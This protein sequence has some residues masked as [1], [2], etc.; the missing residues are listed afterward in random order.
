MLGRVNLC[1]LAAWMAL[2]TGDAFGQ[3][4]PPPG[5]A[6]QP[7]GEPTGWTLPPAGWMAA[8][9]NP[10]ASEEYCP[11]DVDP[12]IV[13][14]LL[15]ADR[16]FGWD[17]DSRLHDA[18]N[19]TSNGMWF[20]L[21]YTHTFIDNPGR[22]LL[23]GPLAA[24]PDPR[25]PFDVF[26]APVP[27]QVAVARVLDV[28]SVDF[29][30]I[31]GI[32]G[33]FGIPFRLGSFEAVFWG[34][35][36]STDVITTDEIPATNPLQDVDVI[37]TSLRNGGAPGSTVIFYDDSFRAPYTAQVFSAEANFYYNYRNPRLGLRIL[38]VL[39]FRH[40]DYDESLLQRGTFTNISGV[41]AGSILNDPLVRKID[42]WVDNNTY[43]VQTGLRS[44]FVHQHFTLG[45]EPRL[46]L[47][48]NHYEAT[49]RTEDL[50]DSPFP[51]IQDDGVVTTNITRDLFSTIFDLQLYAKVHLN[52]FVNLRVGYSYTWLGNISRAHSNI[53]YNDNGTAFPPAVVVRSNED[54]LWMSSFT[55][56]GEIILP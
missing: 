1:V 17:T 42:S 7:Y 16:G 28:S 32:R 31:N 33:T 14:E 29:D 18:L 39:G 44:E 55:I 35:E 48:V 40:T 2:T 47:G 34:T 8:H 41:A 49:V 19:S 10:G 13:N 12:R 23:G 50:R 4:G 24:V 30:N 38:P 53:Y 15:P 6:Y 9:G 27:G 26:A 3:Y 21:E 25:I 56:G 45:V 20:R 37:V 46:T 52:E 51:P 54:N 43:G 11:P 5:G 22:A 36:K